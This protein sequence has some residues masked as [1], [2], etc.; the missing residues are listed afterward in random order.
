[1]SEEREPPSVDLHGLTVERALRR[2]AQSLHAARVRGATRL[3][4]ITGRGFGNLEQRPV[5][6][7]AVEAWLAGA[8]ARGLGVVAH[9]R[10]H[11]GGALD[12]RLG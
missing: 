1:M 6:R 5:L 8:E 7:R 4:V 2:L 9:A 11:K 10:T 12:V 3:L